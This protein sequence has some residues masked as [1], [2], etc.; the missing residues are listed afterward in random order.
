MEAVDLPEL[1][2]IV[3]DRDGLKLLPSS[4]IY[5]A[6]SSGK[7]NVLSAL[8]MM[9][10]IV[11]GAVRLNPGDLIPF[12]PYCLQADSAEEATSLEIDFLL[13]GGRYRYGFEYTRKRI[14]AEWLYVRLKEEG[15]EQELFER[16][17]MRVDV[18]EKYFGEGRDKEGILVENRL[19]VS[20]VAQLNGELSKRIIGWFQN[21]NGIAGIGGGYMG[22]SQSML[23]KDEKLAQRARRFFQQAVLGFEDIRVE[24]VRIDRKT[25]EAVINDSDLSGEAKRQLLAEMEMSEG[26]WSE[27]RLQTLHRVFDSQGHAVAQKLFD[28]E[29]LESNGTKRLVAMSGPIF[30][31]LE[32]GGVLIVDELDAQLHPIL[33]RMVNALFMNPDTNPKGAQLIFALHNTSQM[34]YLRR[35]QIW[36]VEKD[37]SDISHLYSR[38]EFKDSDADSEACISTEREYMQ[39]LYGAIP[40]AP[41]TGEDGNE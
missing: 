27:P 33:T 6:N 38:V 5:G 37:A 17:G 34:D 41:N 22:F 36:F 10:Q 1:R 7:S 13:E 30:H 20:L 16:E 28:Y 2:E 12:D 4:A 29:R 25:M 40:F 18:S 39:G 32:Q 15:E 19:F 14:E 35:D 24:N 9:R 23:Q 31:T 8:G 11:L 3:M 21:C 26:E